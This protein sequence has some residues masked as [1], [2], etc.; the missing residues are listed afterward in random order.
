M[1]CDDY[2][3]RFHGTHNKKEGTV[4]FDGITGSWKSDE[5]LI[6][7][8]TKYKEAFPAVGTP[9]VIT[10]PEPYK[11]HGK[12]GK[13][14]SISMVCSDLYRYTIEFETPYGNV[15]RCRVFRCYFEI[16]HVVD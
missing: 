7:H 8:N 5:I 13:I 16:L 12:R 10:K 2:Y 3:I 14:V 9:V 1:S 15:Q 11:Y 6:I 4:I